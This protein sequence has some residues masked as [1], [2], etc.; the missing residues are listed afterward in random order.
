MEPE[1][2]ELSTGERIFIH[3]YR[4]EDAPGICLLFQAVYGDKYPVK[5]FYKPEEL[6]EA[7]DTGENYSVVARKENGDIIG[8]MAL[9]RAAPYPGLYEC[10]AGLVL[11]EYRQE[12]INQLMLYCVYERLAAELGIAETWGEAVCNHVYM[13][14]TVR[15]YKHIETA[16]EIDL[17]PAETYAKEKSSSGRVTS[18]S[19]FRSHIS[20]PHTVYLP[21]VYEKALRSIYSEL[22]DRR[23][24]EVCG[25]TPPA[26]TCSRAAWE[27]FEFPGVVRIAVT[28]IGEDFESYFNGLENEILT[29]KIKVVQ[30][31]VNLGCPWVGR[32]VE[33]LRGRGYFIG[34]ILP[35]WF[36]E[37][38]LLMQ[39][40]VGRP[41]WEGIH[42]FSDWARE[43]LRIVKNDWEKVA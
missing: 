7:L 38:A 8:H 6:A 9:F 31:S 34:G 33:A 13:Q 20:R 15:R 42:L 16:L 28:A 41:N 3:L 21:T 39:K 22:D 35:R 37:D 19:A 26:G 27:V 4:P 17:M 43:L 23:T 18:L 11:P 5:R 14:K 29:G 10:G 24:I 30:V 1:E 32:A 12:G 36:D 2:C 25:G 40:I